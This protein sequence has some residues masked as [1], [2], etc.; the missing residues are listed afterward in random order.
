MNSAY[1]Y[2][3]AT[4]LLW[5]GF[6][7]VLKLIAGQFNSIQITFSRILVGGLILL[8]LAVRELKKRTLRPD[9]ALFK[10]LLPMSILGQAI[11]LTVN[12]FAVVY[13]PATTVSS[14]A[15]CN[16][17]F[18][19]VF[20]WILFREKIEQKTI[21]SLFIALIGVILIIAPWDLE[22]SFLGIVLTLL[23]PIIFSVYSVL[24]RKPCAKYG[25]VAVTSICFLL[26]ALELMLLSALTHIPFIANL[27][28]SL[29]MD[30]LVEIPF[31]S[32][33][34]WETLPYVLYAYVFSTGIGFCC[35]YVA[36]EKSSAL[37]ASLAF[38][39]KPVLSPVIAF[40]LLGE[41]TS[42]RA[43]IGGGCMLLAL[44]SFVLPDL[45]KNHLHNKKQASS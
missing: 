14:I 11:S 2:I 22:I 10:A 4:A 5:S 6:E 9:K 18:I 32:G 7:A 26:G 42:L 34:T 13:A 3:A 37:H 36:I 29:G 8:P 12:Q 20:A 28:S 45:L 24:I 1:L 41:I 21:F 16:P 15:T 25:G 31:F 44:A 19:A 38:F 30:F 17:I 40:F 43:L 33:Y 27:F 39:L 35:Y 23:S